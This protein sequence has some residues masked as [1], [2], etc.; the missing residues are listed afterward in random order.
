MLKAIVLLK[1]KQGL[2]PEQFMHHYENNHVPLVRT[3]LPSIGKYVR[4]YLSDTSLSA[5]RQEGGTTAAPTPYFDVIT[6]LWFDDSRAYDRFI[7]D[8]NDAQI[9]R[10]LQE[11]EERFLDRSIVQTFSVAEYESAS[12]HQ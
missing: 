1:R 9:S 4:N 10:R 12:P 5:G 6:E 2:T 3:L 8:L 7:A 11:D